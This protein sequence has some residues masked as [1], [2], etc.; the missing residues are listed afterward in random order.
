[1]GEGATTVG[2]CGR[3]LAI[4]VSCGL[5]WADYKVDTLF[6]QKNYLLIKYGNLKSNL[7]MSF[8]PLFTMAAFSCWNLLLETL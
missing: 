1:M 7:R 8:S 3:P 4:N 2:L 5:R 6:P